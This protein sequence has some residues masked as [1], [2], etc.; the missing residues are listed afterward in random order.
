M[1]WLMPV[2]GATAMAL[3]RI[4]VIVAITAWIL[5]MFYNPTTAK[6]N[7]PNACPAV[8]IAT[9]VYCVYADLRFSDIQR[10]EWPQATLGTA[11]LR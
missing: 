3:R 7:M 5:K 4:T 9:F 8:G 10:D 2:I 1:R 6:P 11:R